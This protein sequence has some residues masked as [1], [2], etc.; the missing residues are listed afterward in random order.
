MTDAVYSAPE[1]K[2]TGGCPVDHERL[3]Y[4]MQ[5]IRPSAPVYQDSQGVW[6][7]HGYEEARAILRGNQVKQ[8]GFAAD[9]IGDNN[10]LGREP[11]LY[12][13]GE[14]HHELRRKTAPFFTPTT[15]DREYRTLMNRYADAIIADFKQ[16]KR[17]ELSAMTMKMAVKVAGEIVGL[18][19]S[20]IG[21]MNKR[22]EA[23][24]TASVPELD[25]LSLWD[26]LKYTI[27]QWNYLAY[28]VLD[29]RPAINARRKQPKDDLIS[30]LIAEDYTPA[31]ILTESVLFGAAGMVTTRE[32]IAV[33]FWHIMNNPEW[34]R[35]MREEEQAERYAL[36]H[37]ILRLE[38]V[39]G[40]LYRRAVEDITLE[41]EASTVIIPAGDKIA[42]HVYHANADERIVGEDA[43]GVC[44]HRSM[45][46]M[47]PKVPEFMLSFGDGSH[48]C[49]GAYVA[50]QE[51]DIFLRKLLEVEGIRIEQKPRIGRNEIAEGYELRDFMIV[52]D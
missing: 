34:Q 49:P 18:T 28:F 2:Q 11:M 26:K 16:K 52:C 31:D 6:H 32:F 13:E 46:E 50:I 39:V 48:R 17:A 27:S 38:P 21:G 10:M 41:G 14:E 29:V 44:P 36:L 43:H 19:N 25:K 35:I 51:S 24:F 45:T 8:A 30:H 20:T 42:L 33:A 5:N 37:E 7:V 3:T 40:I 9:S 47:R 12:M 22:L 15:T 1:T 4:D 23:M